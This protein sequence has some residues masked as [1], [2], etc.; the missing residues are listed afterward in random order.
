MVERVNNDDLQW[1]YTH[2]HCDVRESAR[3]Q[4]VDYTNTSPF[5]MTSVDYATMYNVVA[6]YEIKITA[7]DLEHLI[8]VLKDADQQERIH[9]YFPHL[10]QAWMDYKCEVA[11]TV[12]GIDG[13]I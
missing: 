10:R 5:G 7:H 13:T 9:R 11:L 3:R 8:R 4:I 2:L 6:E 12:G 1:L